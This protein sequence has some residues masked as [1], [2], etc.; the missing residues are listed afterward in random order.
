MRWRRRKRTD[1]VLPYMPPK[2]VRWHADIRPIVPDL[3]NPV[4]TAWQA[5]VYEWVV[6][7]TQADSYGYG[8]LTVRNTVA[9]YTYTNRML[10]VAKAAALRDQLA[11][12]PLAPV[13]IDKEAP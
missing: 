5:E 8:P 6:D 1:A 3:A 7:P 2:P 11:M 10:A 12:M 4:I 13:D 9:V